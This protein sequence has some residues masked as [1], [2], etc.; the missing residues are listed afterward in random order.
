MYAGS[1][2]TSQLH[3]GYTVRFPKVPKFS[4]TTGK[5]K[6]LE[7][8]PISCFSQAWKK[9]HWS[10]MSS[11]LHMRTSVLTDKK[12]YIDILMSGFFDRITTESKY[13]IAILTGS[14]LL[15]ENTLVLYTATPR[16]AL[17][18]VCWVFLM[19]EGHEL[20]SKVY[21]TFSNFSIRA[22]AHCRDLIYQKK[23][24]L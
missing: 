16:F 22:K 2:S 6:S 10:N 13:Y 23:G 7:D 20:V 18:L 12:H 17:L 11:D 1:T 15:A 19:W 24:T 14:V 5:K 21:K 3:L 9:I 8:P 4:Q